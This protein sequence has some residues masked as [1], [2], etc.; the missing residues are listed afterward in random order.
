[1]QV[2]D[3]DLNSGLGPG[4]VTEDEDNRT[5]QHS[6]RVL[7]DILNWRSEANLYGYPLVIDF[8]CYN[9]ISRDPSS[10]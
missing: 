1:M 2:I 7:C 3:M 6:R 10:L 9:P 4:F 8:T 5:W